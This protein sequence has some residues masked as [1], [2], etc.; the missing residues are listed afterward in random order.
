G[1]ICNTNTKRWQWSDGS[2]LDYKPPSYDSNLDQPC[3]TG[4]SWDIHEG[5]YW[6]N[7]T[8]NITKSRT[9]Y[10]FCTLQLQPPLS[11][12][13]CD[14][15]NEE[16]VDGTCYQ[17]R[18]N[19]VSWQDA[20]GICRSL[21]STVASIH[22]LEA[23]QFVRREAL[24]QGAV[25]G[26][27]I[28]ATSPSNT[29]TFSWIDGSKWDYQ[30]YYPGFPIA[31]KGQCLAMDTFSNSGE[32]M[33]MDCNSRMGVAC[34]RKAESPH[35]NCTAG[36]W[37]EG[38]VI[39]SPGYPYDASEPCDYF[40]TVPPGKRVRVQ[41]LLLEANTCCDRLV[42]EDNL[43]GGNIVANLTGEVTG[44]YYTTLSSNFMRVS[45]QPK[46]GV[47]VRGTV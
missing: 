4:T 36:P 30:N 34:A 28:G 24:V 21:G 19:A 23:N 9:L 10:V 15:V 39:Y 33:N 26:I 6:S 40:L 31:G 41:V 8:N 3:S 47:N 17:V 25:N 44:Q 29:N 2:P 35:N 11:G 46:G 38:Q 1:L 32:W 20:Q 13:G 5:G 45:W 14:G 37:N 7:G 18:S 12:D 43:L 16:R 22:S 27:Y 42:M